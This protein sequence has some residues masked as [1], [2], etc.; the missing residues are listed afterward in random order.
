[1][2]TPID[3]EGKKA[4]DLFGKKRRRRRRRSPSPE[5]GSDG[6]LD[7]DGPRR[8]KKEKKQK[9][10]QQYKS[11]QFIEDSD[12]EYGDIEAFLEKEKV[13]RER[14]QRAAEASGVQISNMKAQGTRKRRRKIA[15]DSRNKRHK[16]DD[17]AN[18]AGY[19]SPDR[20]TGEEDDD[21]AS[22]ADEPSD[23]S[24]SPLRPKPRP[25]GK[26]SLSSPA[27]TLTAQYFSDTSETNEPS[28]ATTI[29]G[30]ALKR[31]RVVI[32]DEDDD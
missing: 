9:E 7:D 20:G 14:A 15:N 24:P 13:M 8:K 17:I 12:E 29:I 27:A 30:T 26:S 10:K 19:E 28:P 31:S 32:S 21:N 23:P 4:S 1:M 11:A 5:S 22:V 3:L 18:V 6:V 25:L 16:P 2:K